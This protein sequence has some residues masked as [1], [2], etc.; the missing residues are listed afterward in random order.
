MDPILSTYE[1]GEGL[2]ILFVHGWQMD[3]RAEQVDFE[4][5]FSK[6]SG[7]R[8]VYVDLPGMGTS[9]ANGIRNLDDIYVRLAQFIETRLGGSRFLLVGSSC[10]GYFAHAWLK[11]S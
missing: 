2:P 1:I 5:I 4:P 9:P 10:G 3:H 7:F 6:I 8:R 11:D